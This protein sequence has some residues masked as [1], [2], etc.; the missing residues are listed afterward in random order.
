MVRRKSL[1][2][3]FPSEHEE[4]LLTLIETYGSFEDLAM[5]A[6]YFGTTRHALAGFLKSNKAKD[7]KTRYLPGTKEIM[8][9]HAQLRPT[10]QELALPDED[11]LSEQHGVQ[12]I[13]PI[14][15]GELSLLNDYAIGKQTLKGKHDRETSGSS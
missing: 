6:D 9:K 1:S 14:K 3:R 5:L 7:A 13:T 11:A 8:F 2:E 10:E 12:I 15:P 4:E